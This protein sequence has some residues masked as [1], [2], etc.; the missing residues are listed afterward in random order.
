MLKISKDFT[1][2]DIR[3]IRTDFYERHKDLDWNAMIKEIH[4]EAAPLIEE[5]KIRRARYV[6]EHGGTPA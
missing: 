6:A 4:E 1:L 2:E 3:A 5:L